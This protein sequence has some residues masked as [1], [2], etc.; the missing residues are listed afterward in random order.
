MNSSDLAAFIAA[1]TITAEII[2]MSEHTPTV[3]VAAQMLGVSV[4]RVAK[5]ILFLADG[6]PLLV[7]ANGLARIDYKRLADYLTLSRKKVRMAQADEVLDIAGFVVGSMPP[8][9]HKTKLRTLLADRLFEQPEVFAGGG[10]LNAMLR[11]T[12][13]EIERVTGGVKVIVTQGDS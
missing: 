7:I 9:G 1:H 12:P 4:D 13:Q 2:Q 8:F 6:S 10:D 5:S 3:E 11:V